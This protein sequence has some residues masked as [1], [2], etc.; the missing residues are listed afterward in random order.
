MGGPTQLINRL[1][2]LCSSLLD[3]KHPNSQDRCQC[4]E[5]AEGPARHVCR[6]IF[7]GAAHHVGSNRAV[8]PMGHLALLYFLSGQLRRWLAVPLDLEERVPETAKDQ[9][10]ETGADRKQRQH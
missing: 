8:S 3:R 10:S 7:A 9:Y 6:F 1:A 2:G 4:G 5:S